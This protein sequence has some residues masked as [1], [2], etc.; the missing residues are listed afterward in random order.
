MSDGR[1]LLDWLAVELTVEGFLA[2]HEVCLWC[3]DTIPHFTGFSTLILM[4]SL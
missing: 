3:P 1:T 2:G 4:I